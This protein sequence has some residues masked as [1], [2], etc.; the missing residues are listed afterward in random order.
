MK[1]LTKIVLCVLII[2]MLA[3]T[4]TAHSGRTDSSG[5]HYNHSTGTYHYHHGYPAHSHDN[6]C[7]YES[8]SSGSNSGNT[9]S[10][11][12]PT[13]EV[14]TSDKLGREFTF[15]SFLRIIGFAFI[16]AVSGVSF[17][18]YCF[19]SF[20]LKFL[21]D[22]IFKTNLTDDSKDPSTLRIVITTII[23]SLILASLYVIFI[24]PQ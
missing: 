22:L 2:L 11:K 20:A 4:A 6:G 18:I 13:Y 14:N 23:I 8:S 17:L 1:I 9:S 7:P 10:S 15:E 21:I 19:G 24:E 5:G 12:N 16:F 3:V